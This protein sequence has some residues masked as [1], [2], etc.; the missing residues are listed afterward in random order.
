M[1]DVKFLQLGPGEFFFTTLKSHKDRETVLRPYRLITTMH[2]FWRTN[3]L[4]HLR[5][6]ADIILLR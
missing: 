5:A 3:I 2:C 1:Q 6:A 4:K